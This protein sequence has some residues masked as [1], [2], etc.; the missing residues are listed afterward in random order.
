MGRVVFWVGMLVTLSLTSHALALTALSNGIDRI[1]AFLPHLLIA[2]VLVGIGVAVGNLCA[3]LIEESTS[4]PRVLAQSVR[5]AVVVLA[6]LMALDQIGVARGIVM[7]VL[8]A[9]LGSVAIAAAIAFGVGNRQLAGD[10]T[11][12]WV[13]R[14]EEARRER[15]RVRRAAEPPPGEPLPH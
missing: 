3:R 12:R 11:Q 5:V 7:T 13:R 14:A 2:A 15:E 8:V 6:S 4:A 10:Y 9:L 1:V